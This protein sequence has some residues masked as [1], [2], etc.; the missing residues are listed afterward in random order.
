MVLHTTPPPPRSNDLA[1]TRALVPGGPLASRK[2][3][4]NGIRVTVVFRDGAMAAPAAGG[5]ILIVD[6]ETL[7]CAPPAPD[8]AAPTRPAIA[9]ISTPSPPGRT[10]CSSSTPGSG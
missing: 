6:P 9:R 7:P 1:I 2:G 8:V 10:W 5:V 4:S 3:F